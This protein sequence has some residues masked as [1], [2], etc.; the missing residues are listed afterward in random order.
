M[1]KRWKGPPA[2]STLARV[3]SGLKKLQGSDLVERL[4]FLKVHWPLLFKKVLPYLQD[5]GQLPA[6]F[7]NGVGQND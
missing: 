4:N 6:Q 1:T 5:I 7:L 2:P 3:K